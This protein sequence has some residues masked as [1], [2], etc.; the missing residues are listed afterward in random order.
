MSTQELGQLLAVGEGVVQLSANSARRE[1]RTG[2]E[3]HTEASA[4]NVAARDAGVGRRRSEDIRTI[5]C[6]KE[7]W[8]QSDTFSDVLRNTANAAGPKKKNFIESRLLS[9]TW[10][11]NGTTM[12]TRGVKYAIVSLALLAFTIGATSEETPQ[13]TVREFQQREL[14]QVAPPMGVGGPPVE[15]PPVAT[16]PQVQEAA[17]APAAAESGGTSMV[18]YIFIYLI[19]VGLGVGGYMAFEK[20]GAPFLEAAN[21]PAKAGG[22]ASVTDLKAK[23]ERLRQATAEN[24]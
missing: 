9:A 11:V 13:T 16:E 12:S 7:R 6:A 19:G 18:V 22:K 10:I 17:A 3:T 1:A 4:W 8:A 15:G 23:L 14:L 5:G 21:Q 24:A 20:Y 2:V